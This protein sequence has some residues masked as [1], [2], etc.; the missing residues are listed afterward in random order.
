MVGVS[1]SGSTRDAKVSVNCNEEDT[2]CVL[3]YTLDG[4][5]PNENSIK[6]TD[7]ESIIIENVTPGLF[8]VFVNGLIQSATVGLIVDLF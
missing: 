3:R 5:K 6:Y 7:G 4:G 8:E 1:Y 2:D